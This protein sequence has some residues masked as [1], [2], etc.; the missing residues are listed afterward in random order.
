MENGWRQTYLLE[1]W[2]PMFGKIFTKTLLLESCY[3]FDL[4]FYTLRF[5]GYTPQYKRLFP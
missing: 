5:R 2:Q 1:V 4:S 3:H